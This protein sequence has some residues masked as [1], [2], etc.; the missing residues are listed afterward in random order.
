MRTHRVGAL[1]VASVVM[2]VLLATN[3]VVA[4]SAAKITGADIEN[5]TVTTADIQNRSLL[6][7]D[8]KQGQITRLRIE[9]VQW[10]L[11]YPGGGTV[12]PVS[13]GVVVGPSTGRI[14][15]HSRITGTT[16]NV[17][18]DFSACTREFAVQVYP[19]DGQLGSYQD[20]WFAE[21]VRLGD[22]TS[23]GA[24]GTVS[25]KFKVVVPG[26]RHAVRLLVGA[27]CLAE[28][29]GAIAPPAFSATVMAR[30]E[31]VPPTVDRQLGP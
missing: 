24:P 1:A 4:E 6:A 31:G 16:I 30:V 26:S 22:N 8:F 18:G 29:G 14:P 12:D 20:S 27:Y 11:S 10:S 2:G 21:Y 28:P 23:E 25:R 5:G 19:D 13:H 17:E 3:P 9:G 7:K 15:N